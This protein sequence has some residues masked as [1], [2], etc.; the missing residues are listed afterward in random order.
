VTITEDLFSGT[1]PLR[2]PSLKMDTFLGAAS[3][4]EPPL[5]MIFLRTVTYVNCL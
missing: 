2:N 4:R 1:V 5:K 3:L